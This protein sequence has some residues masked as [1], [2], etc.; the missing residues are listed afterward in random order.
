[1]K[2]VTKAKLFTIDELAMICALAVAQSTAQMRVSG[3]IDDDTAVKL[4]KKIATN[5][6]L[7]IACNQ[8]EGEK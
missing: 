3:E 4:N 1:M 5:I 7:E 8:V 2:N 6:S